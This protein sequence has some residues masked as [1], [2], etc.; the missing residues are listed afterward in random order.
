[1]SVEI[2]DVIRELACSESQG[3]ASTP[4]E[5][6]QYIR[7]IAR[8]RKEVAMECLEIA[9]GWDFGAPIEK[10]IRERFGL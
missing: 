2:E 4:E 3:R 10:E 9:K 7:D 5:R 8:V 6:H 1:M